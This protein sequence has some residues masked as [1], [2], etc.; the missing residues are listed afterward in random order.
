MNPDCY[1]GDHTWHGTSKCISCDAR[2]T[3]TCGRFTREDKMAEHVE[4]CA[5]VEALS[6]K[7]GSGSEELTMPSSE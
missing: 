5:V 4:V 3:C 7:N 1:Y 2:L 6:N